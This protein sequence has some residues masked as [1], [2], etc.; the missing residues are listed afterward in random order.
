ME[1][2][3]GCPMALFG[4][5]QNECGHSRGGKGHNTGAGAYMRL[6]EIKC[7]RMGPKLA[8]GYPNIRTNRP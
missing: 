3:S 6:L 8:A 5:A 1:V 4:L 7:A 2:V